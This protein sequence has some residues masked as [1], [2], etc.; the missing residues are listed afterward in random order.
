MGRIV[1]IAGGEL[2]TTKDIN[3]YSIKLTKKSNPNVLFV[4]TASHDAEGYIEA[5]TKAFNEPGCEV[6]SLCLYAEEFSAR[7]MDELLAWADIIYVGGGDTISMMKRWKEVGLD[8]KIKTIYEKDLA[9]LTG[10]SAGGI[11][12]FNC[13]HSDSQYFWNPDDWSYCFAEGM[14]D[15]FHY[16]YCPHYNEEGRDSFDEMLRSKDM[17]GLAMEND[18]AFV[19]NNGQQYYIRSNENANAYV[20]RYVDDVMVK[21]AVE[22]T[23]I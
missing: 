13:G 4:P 7:E 8:Q 23:E 19:E 5:I 17:V 9:V 15:I 20:I 18:T 14:L 12:W 16:A 10:L 1:A 2:D 21:E 11:C 3:L 22:F 6:K